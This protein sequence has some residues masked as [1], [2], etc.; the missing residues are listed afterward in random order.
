MRFTIFGERL[1]PYDEF[2]SKVIVHVGDH[3]RE[4]AMCTEKGEEEEMSSDRVLLQR[5][6]SMLKDILV[7]RTK[8]DCS[9]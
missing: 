4:G 7:V 3:E 5:A 2:L 9:S 1:Y 8:L 6:R